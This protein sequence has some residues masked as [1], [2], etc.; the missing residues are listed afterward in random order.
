MITDEGL[1]RDVRVYR[2]KLRLQRL[3]WTGL[4]GG[5]LFVVAVVIYMLF[6]YS[7]QEPLLVP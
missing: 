6:S 3:K 4:V 5:F 2:R 7:P 1:E